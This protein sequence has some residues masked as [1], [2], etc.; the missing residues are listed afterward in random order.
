MAEVRE[1]GCQCGE[2]RYRVEGEPLAVTVCHCTECQR[3]SGSAFG[4][5]MV[6]QVDQL[7]LT[8]GEPRSFKRDTASGGTTECFFC[9]SCGTR[10]HH[11]PSWIPGL[12]NVK[13]G[14]LD[15]TGW[16]EPTLQVWLGSKQPW[17]PVLAEL[18]SFDANPPRPSRSR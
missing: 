9:A 13:P 17:A 12:V 15:D 14:T 1:G 4:M 6:L 10:T 18:P 2:L 11:L 3:Q 7:R 16:L 5:S 8:Q